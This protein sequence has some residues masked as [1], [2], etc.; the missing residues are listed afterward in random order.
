MLNSV[1]IDKIN[2]GI[3]NIIIIVNFL[4]KDLV[5]FEGV[6]DECDE[7]SEVQVQNDDDG[8]YCFESSGRHRQTG[9]K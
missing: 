8:L 9:D 1:L 6:E 4:N 3:K 5:H 2:N 7:C